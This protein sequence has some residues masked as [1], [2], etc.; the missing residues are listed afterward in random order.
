VLHFPEEYLFSTVRHVC[1]F[2][3]CSEVIYIVRRPNTSEVVKFSKKVQ[4]SIYT[5][6]HERQY[7]KMARISKFLAYFFLLNSKNKIFVLFP[8]IFQKRRSSH[9]V[10]MLVY[11]QHTY[12]CTP[13]QS[14]IYEKE[15]PHIG[16]TK[17]FRIS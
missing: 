13:V 14:H 3:E 11:A 17:N 6:K 5:V 4:N 12:Q 10:D 7:W 9:V 1:C 8:T 16:M 2:N 15:L